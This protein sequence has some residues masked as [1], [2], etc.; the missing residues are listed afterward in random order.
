MRFGPGLAPRTCRQ[1][2]SKAART[3]NHWPPFP[4]SETVS[5]TLNPPQ[6][7]GKTGKKVNE[8][9]SVTLNSLEE[10]GENCGPIPSVCEPG[11]DL[12]ILR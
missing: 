8:T 9:V 6:N 11:S 1:S 10:R 2:T 4:L 3:Q 12:K 7:W 5:A